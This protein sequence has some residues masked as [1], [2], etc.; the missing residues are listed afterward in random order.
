MMR[1]ARVVVGALSLM[2]MAAPSGAQLVITAGLEFHVNTYTTG[3]QQRAAVAIE[4]N[5]DFVV[6]WESEQDGSGRGVFGRRYTSEGAGLGGEFRINVRTEDHQW[7]PKV[8]LDA[9][10]DFVVVWHGGSSQDGSGYGVFGRRYASNGAAIGGEFQV[11][12]Y[13][14]GFQS[15][16]AAAMDTTGRFVV[17]WQTYYQDGSGFAIFLQSFDSSGARQGTEIQINSTQQ[18]S[19]VLPAVALNDA[20]RFVVAW[21]S[22]GQ[23]GSGYGVFAKVMDPGGIQATPEFRVASLTADDQTA[24]SVGMVAGGGFVITWTTH[25]SEGDG[26]ESAVW[27]ERFDSTGLGYGEMLINRYTAQEQSESVVAVAPDGSFIVTWTDESLDGD[28]PGIFARRVAANGLT[29]G[30]DFQINVAIDNDQMRPAIALAG[31]RFVI[32]WDTNPTG[33]ETDVIARRGLVSAVLDIDGD[34]FAKP[35]TDGM[36][37]LRYLSEFAGSALTAGAVGTHCTRCTPS[38]VVSYLDAIPGSLDIDDDGPLLPL[39][40]G[41]L[42]LRYLFG[43]RGAALESAV[44]PNCD[45]CTAAELEQHIAPLV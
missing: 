29:L 4:S 28:S 45:R 14:G 11:N 16:P 43:F 37:V 18:F 33:L 35:L 10:G 38:A 34:G 31:G 22:F 9:D 39:H 24:A 19:Q 44:S 12:M 36:L 8:A 5:G 27:A 25:G 15:Y 23:D 26:A 17:A 3:S 32:A 13:T 20:G 2:L 40:D 1:L 42:V 7:A 30:T 41:V 6:V 21:Q